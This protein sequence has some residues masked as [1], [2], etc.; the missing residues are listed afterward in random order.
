GENAAVGPRHHAEVDGLRVAERPALGH[1]DR[2]DVADQ[3]T[4]AGVWRGELLAVAVPGMAPDDRQV[5]AEL[6]RQPPAARTNRGVRVVVYLAALDGR[7]PVVEQPGHRADQPGLPLA[8]LAEQDD[9]VPGDERALDVRQD[10]LVEPD[11]AGKPV[12]PGP[13]PR[14]QGLS[15]FLLDASVDVP[16]PP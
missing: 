13:H 2:V 15:Y 11:D 1:L 16:A 4:D 7:G 8:A 3:V 9:V 14:E 5:V 12:L 10:T 6:G